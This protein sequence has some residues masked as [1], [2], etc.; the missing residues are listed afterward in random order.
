[1]NK[2]AP[3]APDKIDPTGGIEEIEDTDETEAIDGRGAGATGTYLPAGEDVGR[4]LDLYVAGAAGVSRTAAA[5]L[6]ETGAV[7]VNGRPADKKYALRAGDAVRVA[8]PAPAET[9][10]VPQ[11]IP[12]DVVYEDDD[13][14]VIDK[15][16]GMVVH[17]APGN[18]DGTL[19]N[20]L[21]AHCGDS[22]S[23]IGGEIRPGIVHRIDRDTSGLLVV[24]KNDAAHRCLSE[25][26]SGH[27]LRRTYFALVRG[28]PTDDEGTISLPLG[29]DP[30]DRKKMAVIRDPALRSREAVTHYTVRE[31]FSGASLL[32]LELETGRTHQIRVHMAAIGHPV[33]GDPLYGGKPT[34]LEK[35]HARL[36]HGQCLHA[37]RLRFVHPRT[38]EEMTVACPPPPDF[39]KLLALLRADA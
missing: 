36:L 3:N 20:A 9:A 8:L 13:L 7:L 2:H 16:Q 39:E 26:L 4:R 5:R 19:V 1:M 22:L 33:L 32:E 14:L 18:P 27:R 11:D 35:K 10:A 25:Q 6:I 29:R 28:A 17:P 38:G 12:L 34:P 31:R 30:R 37:G 23:G 24:A 21:L 15:P